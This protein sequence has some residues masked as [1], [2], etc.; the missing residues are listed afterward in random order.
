MERQLKN[1]FYISFRMCELIFLMSVILLLKEYDFVGYV[2]MIISLIASLIRY[3]ISMHFTNLEFQE[4]S[5]MVEIN[6]ILLQ[7]TLQANDEFH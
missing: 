6:N 3:S 7:Q 4:Y 1:K 5:R 2:L